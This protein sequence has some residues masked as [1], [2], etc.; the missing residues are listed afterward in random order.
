MTYPPERSR[1]AD[2]A[3]TTPTRLGQPPSR[4]AG[5][6]PVQ[7]DNIR[8]PINER[9]LSSMRSDAPPL[10]PIFRSRRQADLLAILFLRPEKDHT[11]TELAAQL[12][13]SLPTLHREVNRLIASELIAVRQVG[14]SRLLRANMAN[15]ASGPLAQLL[16]VT[17][18]PHLIVAEEFA[19]LPDT[20]SVVIFG[21]WAARY[22]GQPGP[23]PNDIDVL[24]IGRPQRGDVYDAADRAHQRLGI[25]INPVIR[26]DESWEAGTDPLIA[27]I[28]ASPTTVAWT[29]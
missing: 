8:L 5:A 9:Y 2:Q 27:Q 18:G 21:S 16:L 14:R 22:D 11:L 20:R 28:K 10:A 29:T 12:D 24:V 15:R 3:E 26:A 7:L 6:H 19:S 25:P 17:V 4:S 23:P 13:A 1:E